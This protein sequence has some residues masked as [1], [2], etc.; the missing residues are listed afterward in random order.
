MESEKLELNKILF[1]FIDINY[2]QINIFKSLKFD[3]KYKKTNICINQKSN[4]IFPVF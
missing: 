2:I 1:N 3:F 4:D